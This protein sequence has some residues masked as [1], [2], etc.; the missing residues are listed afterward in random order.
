[1]IPIINTIDDIK[2][3]AQSYR[4]DFREVSQNRIVM[5]ILNKF[6]IGSISIE[7]NEIICI[8]HYD[9]GSIRYV[10]KF[11]YSKEEFEAELK[12]AGQAFFDRQAYKFKKILDS[13]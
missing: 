6:C 9:R 5:Y 3:I 11:K 2:E 8:F 4:I 10:N 13:I 7:S 1:M 12:K